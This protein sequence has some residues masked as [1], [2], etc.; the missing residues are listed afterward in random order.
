MLQIA[1]IVNGRTAV[2]SLAP[3]PFLELLNF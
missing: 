3:Q 2:R 1:G